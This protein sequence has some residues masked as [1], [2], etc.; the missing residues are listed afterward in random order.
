MDLIFV[1]VSLIA[2]QITKFLLTV[3]VI[4]LI[5][6]SVDLMIGL[7]LQIPLLSRSTVVLH[8]L[9]FKALDRQLAFGLHPHLLGVIE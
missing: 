2:H 5:V 3:Q 4:V 7:E 1:L 8:Q 9:V 6:V